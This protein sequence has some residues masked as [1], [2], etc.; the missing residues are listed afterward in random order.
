M[1]LTALIVKDGAAFSSPL[2]GQILFYLNLLHESLNY[3]KAVPAFRFN[4]V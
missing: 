1:R 3:K 2:D 4:L